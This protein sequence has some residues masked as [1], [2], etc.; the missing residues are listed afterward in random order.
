MSLP[1]YNS[2][3]SRYGSNGSGSSSGYG[4]N[5]V[6]VILILNISLRI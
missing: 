4:S 2:D 1:P 5:E 3:G 6:C